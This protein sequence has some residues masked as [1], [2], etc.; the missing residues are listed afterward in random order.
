MSRWRLALCGLAACG[1]LAPAGWS[2]EPEPA[3]AANAADD[4]QAA[5]FE[6]MLARRPNDPALQYNLGTTRYRG[7]RYDQ[8]ADSLGAAV[9]SSGPALRG[10]ASY[11]LG[12]THYQMGRQAEAASPDQ[13]KTAYTQALEDYR[14]A[15]RQDPAD[16]DAKYNYELVTRRLEVLQAQPPPQQQEGG[17]SQDGQS[18][19]SQP[20]EQSAQS[21][22]QAASSPSQQDQQHGEQQ[23][24]QHAQ[25]QQPQQGQPRDESQQAQAEDGRDRAPEQ[26][27]SQ[28]AGQAETDAEREMSQQQAVWILDTLKREE[29]RA[30]SNEQRGPGR[31]AHV[32]QDW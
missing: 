26:A 19:S 11:N 7:G 1:W 31:E 27:Q 5:R 2:A 12:N 30:P 32:E 24:Q 6:R 13:A 10:R 28:Q 17:Q 21:E 4:P 18:Q 20:Q 23:E 25:Q 15:I 29:Q 3:A 22:Q 8:A 14:L 9:A 16:Q